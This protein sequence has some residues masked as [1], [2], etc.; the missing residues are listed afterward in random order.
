MTGVSTTRTPAGG[1]YESQSD[2]TLPIIWGVE[3]LRLHDA[4]W[5][6]RCVQILRPGMGSQAVARGPALYLLLRPEQLVLHSLEAVLKRMHWASP[7]LVRLR[8]I[9][10]ERLGY[11]ERVIAEDDR[12]RFARSYQHAIRRSDRAWLTADMSLARL[13]AGSPD[14]Q[15]AKRLLRNRV[16]RSSVLSVAAEGVSTCATPEGVREWVENAIEQWQRPNVVLP[17]LYEYQPGV[18]IHESASIGEDVRFFGKAWI[19]AGVQFDRNVT[20]VGPIVLGDR[21]GGQADSTRSEHGL[22]VD[23]DLTRSPHWSLPGLT[24]RAS[25]RR[26][27][28]RSFDIVFSGFVLA[29]TLPLYP[30]VML[31]IAIEDGRPFFFAHRRQ[32]LNGRE[33]PCLKFRTMRK[34]AEKIKAELIK[35]NAADGPQFFME[36]DPR[37]T[38]VGRYLRKFQVDELPQF[39]NVL[40]G[41]MSVV[42]PRPSPDKENQFCPTWREARLSI[43]PGVTGLWQVKRTRE[44]LTDF[45]EWIRYDLEYVQHQSF[46]GDLRIIAETVKHIVS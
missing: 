34:D 42:G 16:E 39:V 45:Q 15:L 41:H 20:I 7:R 4:L 33:F 18:W 21:T 13:W 25:L 5:A 29:C 6:S 27:I 30:I 44:P 46:V 24:G 35:Q 28:K 36:N 23:W 9:T 26:S 11:A 8:I 22:K 14:A 17:E 1:P 38:K 40:L 19:G 10:K 2:Q 43:R 32:T 31:A 3:P 37:V 12:I